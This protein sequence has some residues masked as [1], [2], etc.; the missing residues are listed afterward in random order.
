MNEGTCPLRME[1]IS[2]ARFV[3]KNKNLNTMHHISALCLCNDV[4]LSVFTYAV[5]LDLNSY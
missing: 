2:E 5:L 4:P 1:Y 3:G